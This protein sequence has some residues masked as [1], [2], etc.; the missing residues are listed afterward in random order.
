[1]ARERR[2]RHAAPLFDYDPPR[3]IEGTQFGGFASTEEKAAWDALSDESWER[4]DDAEAPH[5]HLPFTKQ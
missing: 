1:M 4:L 5:G 2:F 3:P